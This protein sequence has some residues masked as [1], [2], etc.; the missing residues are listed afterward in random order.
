MKCFTKEQMASSDE[1]DKAVTEDESQKPEEVKDSES[2]LLMNSLFGDVPPEKPPVRKLGIIGDIAEEKTSDILYGMLLLHDSREVE[3][4]K[5]PED[6][7]SELE[8]VSS[9]LRMAVM[10]E[11][12]LLS[13]I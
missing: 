3:K 7:E 1:S 2:G 8:K 13:T 6:P 11:K 10:P 9:S 12:C 5:D 4:P